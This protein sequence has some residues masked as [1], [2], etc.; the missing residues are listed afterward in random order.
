MDKKVFPV[1]SDFMLP[2]ATNDLFNQIFNDQNIFLDRIYLC[3][4]SILGLDL[5]NECTY[6]HLRKNFICTEMFYKNKTICMYIHLNVMNTGTHD[7][8]RQRN[9]GTENCNVNMNATNDKTQIIE[10][11]MLWRQQFSEMIS[12]NIRR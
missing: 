6:K 8:Y 12:I 11:N 3:V 9:V 1:P 5:L 10:I 7:N 4:V 2:L